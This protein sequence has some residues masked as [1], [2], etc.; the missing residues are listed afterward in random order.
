[1]SDWQER[2]DA[3]WAA[4]DDLGDAEVIRRID[5]L[6]GERPAG[7]PIALFERAGARE[8]LGGD[9]LHC[10]PGQAGQSPA[11]AGTHISRLIVVG[12]GSPR[13]KSG[14]TRDDSALHSGTTAVASTSIL[15]AFSTRPATCTTAIAG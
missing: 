11:R 13:T 1:M 9:Q 3:V 12:P 14:V 10:H 15:A 6:A 4:A 5:A 2:V 7:D 8:S